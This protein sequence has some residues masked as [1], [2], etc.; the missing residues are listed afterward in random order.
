MSLRA[1]RVAW[2]LSGPLIAALTQGNTNAV[3]RLLA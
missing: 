1:T 3:K 2:R